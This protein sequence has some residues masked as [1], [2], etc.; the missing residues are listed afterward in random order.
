VLG[1]PRTAAI[2]TT[3]ALMI[4]PVKELS[5]SMTAGS[6]KRLLNPS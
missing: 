6:L 2:D 5:F 1:E 3:L 4:T